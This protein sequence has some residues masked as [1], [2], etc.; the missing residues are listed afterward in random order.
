MDFTVQIVK[1][2][3]EGTFR[4]IVRDENIKITTK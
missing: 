1:G 3:P 4:G 2:F